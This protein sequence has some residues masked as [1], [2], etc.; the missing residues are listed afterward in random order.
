[1]HNTSWL[2]WWI[3]HGAEKSILGLNLIED[4]MKG[5]YVDHQPTPIVK[6]PQAREFA[7]LLP[8]QSIL[9]SF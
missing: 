8:S 4:P 2:S 1:M 3:W 7:H 9:W 6:L 5:K